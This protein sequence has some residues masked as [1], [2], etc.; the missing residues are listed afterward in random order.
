MN[1][2]LF[3]YRNRSERENNAANGVRRNKFLVERNIEDDVENDELVMVTQPVKDLC[4]SV[5]AF[6]Y[7]VDSTFT[8]NKGKFHNM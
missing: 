7:V 6:I 1:F 2:K 3:L 4:S 5:D 8:S